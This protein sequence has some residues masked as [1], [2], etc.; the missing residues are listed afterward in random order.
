MNTSIMEE[1]VLTVMPVYLNHCA[2]KLHSHD[3]CIDY[4]CFLYCNLLVYTIYKLHNTIYKNDCCNCA[5]P[6]PDHDESSGR[7]CS[8]STLL[9][10][11]TKLLYPFQLSWTRLCCNDSSALLPSANTLP[12]LLPLGAATDPRI[13]VAIF[14]DLT[15]VVPIILHAG[16]T[17]V[18][19][20][21]NWHIP[22]RLSIFEIW[23]T[24]YSRSLWWIF[25][26]L[27]TSLLY[28][29][30][31]GFPYPLWREH[32]IFSSWGI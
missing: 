9:P 13:F 2:C 25:C 12:V 31:T 22:K 3:N 1:V 15:A 29:I 7:A 19:I 17:D 5:A 11:S 26:Q 20:E 21:L 30:Y 16:Q 10:L 4:S 24:L 6:E 28:I 27:W 18:L 8:A 23:F 32:L 14:L